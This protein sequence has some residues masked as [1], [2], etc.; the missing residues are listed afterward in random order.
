MVT[1]NKSAHRKVST[2]RARLLRVQSRLKEL[3][4]SLK[5]GELVHVFDAADVIEGVVVAIRAKLLALPGKASPRVVVCSSIG[6]VKTLLDDAIRECL[7]E[8][9]SIDPPGRKK[10]AVG[11]AKAARKEDPFNDAP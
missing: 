11:A 1:V 10:G 3:E 7:E 6:E 8:I 4:L 9:A 2:E 5:R